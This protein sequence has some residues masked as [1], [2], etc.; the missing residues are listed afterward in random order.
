MS[1]PKL[2]T[3]AYRAE[4]LE[5]QLETQAISFIN[6][7]SRNYLD[8][9][10]EVLYLSSI[11]KWYKEDFVS[12]SEK[13]E[14]YIVRYLNTDDAEFVRNIKVTIKYLDYD[15]GLNEQK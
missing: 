10:N 9:E 11:F 13:T 8:K 1:C 5:Q 4:K 7:K 3:E 15:W 6:D 12:S 2:V 14:E